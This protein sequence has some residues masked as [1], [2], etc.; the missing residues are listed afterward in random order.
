MYSSRDRVRRAKPNS[1]LHCG[2]GGHSGNHAKSAMVGSIASSDKP[3]SSAHV[4]NS[5]AATIAISSLIVTV[6]ESSVPR[7]SCSIGS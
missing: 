1:S 6:R 2:C 4:A 7:T 3:C 5:V